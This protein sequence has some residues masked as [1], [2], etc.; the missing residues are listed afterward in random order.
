MLRQIAKRSI[1]KRVRLSHLK[2]EDTVN[3]LRLRTIS[4]HDARRSP[5]AAFPLHQCFSSSTPTPPSAGGFHV[6]DTRN[7]ERSPHLSYKEETK[8]QRIAEQLLTYESLKAAVIDREEDFSPNPR[9]SQFIL[10]D[11]LQIVRD[12]PKPAYTARDLMRMVHTLVLPTTDMTIPSHASHALLE[13]VIL[14]LKQCNQS[15]DLMLEDAHRAQELQHKLQSIQIYHTSAYSQEEMERWRR[16][17][18]NC[19]NQTLNLYSAIASKCT[20]AEASK[21]VVQF[22]EALLMEAGSAS[23]PPSQERIQVQPD[24]ISFN[25]VMKAWARA[26]P[27]RRKHRHEDASDQQDR[28]RQQH[29]RH[30]AER[31]EAILGLLIEISQE[32][33]TLQPTEHSYNAVIAAWAHV[34]SA[35]TPKH[36]MD[37]I[38]PKMLDPGYHKLHSVVPTTA[39]L[40]TTAKVLSKHTSAK[41]LQK[42]VEQLLM[43]QR[44]YR[45]PLTTVVCN[46]ILTAYSR[47]LSASTENE[48]LMMS[49]DM[50]RFFDKRVEQPDRLSFI[51][52]S[53]AIRRAVQKAGQKDDPLAE[54]AIRFLRQAIKAGLVD[55]RMYNDAIEALSYHAEQAGEVFQE[56]GDQVDYFSY[57]ALV[58]AYQNAAAMNRSSKKYAEQ[59]EEL[60]KGM[61]TL[62]K[63]DPSLRPDTWLYNAVILSWL[64]S[65][66]LEGVAR[67]D[68]VLRH[69]LD[70]YQQRVQER[71][72]ADETKQSRI[73]ERPN[74]FSFIHIMKG[75]STYGSYEH[76][77]VVE[78]LLQLMGDLQLAKAQS[79]PRH[80]KAMAAVE[81]TSVASNIL[82]DMYASYSNEDKRLVAKAENLLKRKEALGNRS[83][84]DKYSYSILFKAYAAAGMDDTIKRTMTLL[85]LAKRAM[86]GEVTVRFYNGALNALASSPNAE[87]G[88]KAAENL[89]AEMLRLPRLQPDSYSYAAV[90]KALTKVGTFE[91]IQRADQVLQRAMQSD[92]ADSFCFNSVIEGYAKLK[93]AK[94][95]D[96]AMEIYVDMKHESER[97]AKVKPTN[98]TY[99]NL[100]VGSSASDTH[101]L[102][103]R[104]VERY[105][106]SK[107][108]QDMPDG[109]AFSHA[110][111]AWFR[112]G[113]EGA[114]KKAEDVLRLKMTLARE[115]GGPTPT[116]YDVD[117][118]IKKMSVASSIDRAAKLLDEVYLLS[119]GKQAVSTGAYNVILAHY[120]TSQA[121]PESTAKAC[122]LLEKMEHRFQAE[123]AKAKPDGESYASCISAWV[124]SRHPDCDEHSEQILNRMASM[125]EKDD[126]S[127]GRAFN[128]VLKGCK[129][130]AEKAKVSQD[131]RVQR[132]A[133]VFAEMMKWSGVVNS[134]SFAYML[135]LT[136]FMTQ[137]EVRKSQLYAKLMLEC[138]KAGLISRSVLDTF[139]GVARPKLA[140][141]VLN[142]KPNQL[143]SLTV[144]GLPQEWTCNATT[145]KRTSRF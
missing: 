28:N 69:L 67:A 43:Y 16:G 22:A 37:H 82:L 55:V 21:E 74:T 31:A 116:K 14:T 104:R 24:V 29:A 112:D 80:R 39:T 3:A 36:V 96:R 133:R 18:L 60:V 123:G 32:L 62:S 144:E 102:L 141:M 5:P 90:I 114:A 99:S 57:R 63:S 23:S 2:N 94:A 86:Q 53:T 41:E 79:P 19:F 95:S 38:W 139:V 77:D 35:E 45:I 93:T 56:M 9:F 124:E 8:L 128:L 137:D 52:I 65:Q 138:Q 130:C 40:V 134:S 106:Q 4:T 119:W 143:G 68:Q 109:A 100:S 1:R 47:G 131:A 122:S 84:P 88:A 42:H 76:I 98:F 26:V 145:R 44:Q 121:R 92:Q 140:C 10:K 6:T 70:K 12:L 64:E 115:H 125:V 142:V 91:A 105:S 46:A 66:S 113:G 34:H 50:I 89:L 101:D 111:G 15:P 126:R 83:K 59:A 54:D 81:Q 117:S 17:L 30:A 108:Q 7:S 61:E 85:E 103:L 129:Q 33:P 118:V 49:R 73:Q 127:L 75:Y 25:T 11:A 20:N 27:K 71:L 58:V 13:L 48:C 136:S 51:T 135:K 110:I 120:A 132:G 72:G 78:N 107:N 97:N 87:E